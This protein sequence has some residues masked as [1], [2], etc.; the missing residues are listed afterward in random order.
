MSFLKKVKD[1]HYGAEFLS[2]LSASALTSVFYTPLNCF[3]IWKM[4]EV[5][6]KNKGKFTYRE[7]YKKIKDFYGYRGF[8][9]YNKILIKQDLTSLS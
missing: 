7:C 2:Y 4:L 5:T 6:P 8:W 3:K 1:F 9:R